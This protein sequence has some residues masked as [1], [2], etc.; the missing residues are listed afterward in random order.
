M[1]WLDADRAQNSFELSIE[2]ND[3]YSLMVRSNIIMNR[4]I[5]TELS[6][7]NMH[8][9]VQQSNHPI[10]AI[11]IESCKIDRDNK[12]KSLLR[13]CLLVGIAHPTFPL[14]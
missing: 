14:Y 3:R 8:D 9:R 10:F 11:E 6:I 1:A 13:L 2:S 12:P 4:S 5:Q 7:P